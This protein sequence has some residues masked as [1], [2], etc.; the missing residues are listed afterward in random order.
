MITC[1][2]DTRYSVRLPTYSRGRRGRRPAA[3]ARDSVSVH[4]SSSQHD[5]WCFRFLQ[6]LGFNPLLCS[7][8]QQKPLLN[9]SLVATLYVN[10]VWS[11][12]LACDFDDCCLG[13]LVP[14]QDSEVVGPH[15]G[16]APL[17][18]RA[19]HQ[20]PLHVVA[21]LLTGSVV[22]SQFLFVK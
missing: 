17:L 15:G 6:T 18:V 10:I 5:S 7:S 22:A 2:S 21:A 14:R 20:P 8:L 4:N 3:S 19:H 16:A 1:M 11:Y 12:I 13:G 9:S